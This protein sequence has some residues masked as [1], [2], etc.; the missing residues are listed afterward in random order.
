MITNK[1]QT[2]KNT[3]MINDVGWF[4]SDVYDI[5]TVSGDSI[6]TDFSFK[7]TWSQDIV[8]SQFLYFGRKTEI[9]N[10]SYTKIQEIYTLVH[11]KIEEEQYF[12]KENYEHIQFITAITLIIVLSLLINKGIRRGKVME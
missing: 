10:R 3:K 2:F 7:D 1:I 6:L 11:D 8:Y 12:L 9:F 5:S 4:F